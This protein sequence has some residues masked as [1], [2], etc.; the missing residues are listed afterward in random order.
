ME[1]NVVSEWGYLTKSLPDSYDYTKL[2]EPGPT[3]SVKYQLIRSKLPVRDLPD[4]YF[5]FGL[6]EECFSNKYQTLRRRI[7]LSFGDEKDY[8]LAFVDG[9]CVY[10]TGCSANFETFEEQPKIHK[11]FQDYVLAKKSHNTSLKSAP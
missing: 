3:I 8:R 11:L 5:Y 7:A 9:N 1:K 2:S 6:S 10:I 4:T